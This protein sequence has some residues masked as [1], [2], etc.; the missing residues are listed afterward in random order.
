MALRCGLVVAI[1]MALVATSLACA[2]ENPWWSKRF[3]VAPG[4]V[5]SGSYTSPGGI[6]TNGD[7]LNLETNTYWGLGKTICG[8]NCGNADIGYVGRTWYNEVI[9]PTLSDLSP[10][11][12]RTAAHISVYNAAVRW[13][14]NMGIIEPPSG[15]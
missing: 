9:Q 7:M 10:S 15:K 13:W 11:R 14:T 1:A 12:I 6:Y 5:R 2:G 8:F 3:F 4:I